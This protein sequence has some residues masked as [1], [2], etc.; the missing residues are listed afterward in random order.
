M[1]YST[2]ILAKLGEQFFNK[3]FLVSN[4]RYRSYVPK[5][6]DTQA[7]FSWNAALWPRP[8]SG[9]STV[10]K[11]YKIAIFSEYIGRRESRFHSER[12][13]DEGLQLSPERLFG[14]IIS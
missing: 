4:G 9:I 5:T 6:E 3:G 8:F 13:S 1:T 14:L 2:V 11:I 7:Q 12:F 10:G